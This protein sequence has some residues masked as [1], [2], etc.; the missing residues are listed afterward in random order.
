MARAESGLHRPPAFLLGAPRSGT[1]LLY[2]VL[3][4]HP[5]ASWISNFHRKAPALPQVNVVNRL[6]K[7]RPGQRRRVWFGADSNAYVFG[8]GRRPLT[9]RLF[10]MPVEGETVFVSCGLPEDMSTARQPASARDGA[11]RK[12]LSSVVRWGGGQVLV[13]KR[14]GHNRRIPLL[15]SAFPQARFVN[16]VR[17]GRAVALSLSAVDW[18][19]ELEVWW[20]GGTPQDWALAGRDPWELCAQHWVEEVTS[21][22][23]GLAH[24]TPEQVLQVPYED[25][26]A[27]PG[28]V[29]ERIREFV[30]LSPAPAWTAAWQQLRFP[31]RNDRWRDE[32]SPA[33]QD[34]VTGIQAAELKAFSYP[35]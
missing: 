21:V 1:S 22:R 34:V 30:G 33:A 32:L 7:V 25:L 2:K 11:I 35:H 3:C 6:A 10:P 28:P 4:L 15:L 16:L 24:V 29:L 12:N 23:E 13:S 19:P 9:D 26:V 27:D 8:N 20:Q 5:E 18:W 14:I 31:N 17:D